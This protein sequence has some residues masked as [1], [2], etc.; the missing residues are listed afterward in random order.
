M[1]YLKKKLSSQKKMKRDQKNGVMLSFSCRVLFPNNAVCAFSRLPASDRTFKANLE[2]NVVVNG[3]LSPNC[4]ERFMWKTCCFN[5][6]LTGGLVFEIK[7]FLVCLL[8][9]MEKC[10]SG[11][12]GLFCGF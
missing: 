3:S 8:S 7:I 11:E 10:T 9:L 6:F 2:K 4:L 1:Y 12:V 5:L